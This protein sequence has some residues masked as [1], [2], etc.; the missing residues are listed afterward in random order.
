MKIYHVVQEF[1]AFS[2]KYLDRPKLML[3]KPRHRFAYKWLDNI[4]INKYAKF[5]PNILY[6]SRVM[7]IFTNGVMESFVVFVKIVKSHLYVT[8]L[9]MQNVIN[10]YKK[11]MWTFSL[12]CNGWTDGSIKW[13]KCRPMGRATC[14]L[15]I[16]CSS[17]LF[18]WYKG[19][20]TSIILRT[21][22]GWVVQTL[23]QTGIWCACARARVCV[24][25]CVGGP[26]PI[27][28]TPQKILKPR[29]WFEPRFF[30]EI[31]VYLK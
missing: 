31:L 26:F 1:W 27:R 3:G 29:K 15:L 16:S 18:H 30:F 12:T 23:Q 22:K 8:F 2:L 4:K 21:R 13:F 20:N 24:Y 28:I 10:L 7:R 17:H 9:C 11:K 25:V 14:T 19:S 6:V 5:D